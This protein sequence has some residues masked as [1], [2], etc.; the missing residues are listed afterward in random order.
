M[1]AGVP[2]Q[3]AIATRGAVVPSARQASERRSPALV[4]VPAHAP[5][6]APDVFASWAALD[7]DAL[8]VVEDGLDRL[9]ITWVNKACA[10]MFGYAEEELHGGPLSRLLR[11]PFAPGPDDQEPDARLLV[12]ARRALRRHV[13]PEGRAGP[14]WWSPAPPP[15]PPRRARAPPPRRRVPP[16]RT[17]RR[18]VSLERRDGSRLR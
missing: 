17:L 2:P 3:A 15:P 9:R 4:G 10:Q 7:D 16:R 12:D 1:P 18:N 11:S 5:D 14:W 8:I 6:I 13:S